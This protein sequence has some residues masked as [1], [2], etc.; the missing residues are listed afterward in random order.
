MSDRSRL[1]TL[2]P[3]DLSE[4][5]RRF[6]DTLTGGHWSGS[7]ADAEGRLGGPLNAML[8]APDLGEA[9]Q[10][11]SAALRRTSLSRRLTELVILTVGH[12]EESEYEVFQHERIAADAGLTDE[13]LA[14]LREHRE[15][16]LDD[17]VERAAWRTTVRLL[18]RADLDDAEYDEAIG[19]LGERGLVELVAVIG[20]YRMVGLLIETFR[21]ERG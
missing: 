14:A 1:R 4:E 3:G 11:L 8:Y 20:F 15:P 2:R 9:W 18:E 16:P 5:Q 13:Q 7:V 10:T 19:T 21:I 17:P 12:H 6:H